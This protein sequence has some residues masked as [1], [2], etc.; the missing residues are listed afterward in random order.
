MSS[1]WMLVAGAAFAL[2]GVFIKLG[3][4]IHSV[5]ELV[6]WRSIVLMAFAWAALA[7]SGSTIRTARFGMHAHRGIAGFVSLFLFYNAVMTLPLATAMTL[8]YSAPIFLVILLTVQA[9]ERPGAKLAATVFVGFAGVALLL[10]PSIAAD[11]PGPVL[12]GLA[13]GATAAIAYRNVRALAHVDE[14]E[15][16]II[17]YFG[18]WT[19]LGA[20]VWM[21]PQPWHLPT[22]RSA[23]HLAG[24]GL[25]GA[26]GQV[27]MTR[28]YGQG[29]MLVSAALSY[30]AVV[31]SALIGIAVFDDRLPPVAWL[32]IALIVA[33][34]VAAVQLRPARREDAAAPMVND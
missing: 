12:V 20:L 17:F 25:M 7:R 13:S 29:A 18:F 22:P 23:M 9:R 26:I 2:M 14:P 21:V 16:R 10:G 8:S 32:G 27:A 5:G 1:L 24:M 30:S 6:F 19:F 31:F 15:P 4:E 28:A 11:R 3:A 34:G 33:A